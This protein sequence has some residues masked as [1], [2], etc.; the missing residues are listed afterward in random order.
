LAEVQTQ[1]HALKGLASTL[2]MTELFFCCSKVVARLRD[3]ELRG[4]EFSL[5][6]EMR[7]LEE[8]H[9]DVLSGLLRRM[10]V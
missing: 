3:E 8:A 7:M 5:R 9:E 10:D 6:E 2:G 4:D 1:V